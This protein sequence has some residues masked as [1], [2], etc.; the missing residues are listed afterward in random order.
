M[1]GHRFFE[2]QGPAAGPSRMNE[3]LREG[4]GGG[5]GARGMTLASAGGET[6]KIYAAFDKGTLSNQLS[7]LEVELLLVGEKIRALVDS[8]SSHSFIHP[9]VVQKFKL[10]D[11]A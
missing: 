6:R 5:V 10:R 11:L 8:G 7:V 4:S 3:V 9:R 1:A 2:C